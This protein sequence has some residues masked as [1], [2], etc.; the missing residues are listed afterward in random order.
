M[1]GW[2]GS[3]IARLRAIL[4]AGLTGYLTW[5]WWLAGGRLTWVGRGWFGVF[6]DSKF[7]IGGH[8]S[9]AGGVV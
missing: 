7:L 1:E 8:S 2:L 3:K 5:R 4:V 9:R 6:M